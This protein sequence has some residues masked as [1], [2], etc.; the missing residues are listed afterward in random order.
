MVD[1]G[2]NNDYDD[3]EKEVEFHQMILSSK[4][5]LES[6]LLIFFGFSD[7]ETRDIL[8]SVKEEKR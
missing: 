4:K 5:M 8:E 3:D 7:D 6:L 1:F 2:L